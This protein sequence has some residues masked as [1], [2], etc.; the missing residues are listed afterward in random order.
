MAPGHNVLEP[1]TEPEGSDEYHQLGGWK[2]IWIGL[3]RAGCGG[4]LV[5][6]GRLMRAGC[7]LGVG[8]KQN[9]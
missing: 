6:C 7:A 8:S 9:R 4:S 2:E 5:D 1:C 3:L